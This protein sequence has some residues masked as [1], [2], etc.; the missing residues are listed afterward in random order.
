[1]NISFFSGGPDYV[2]IYYDLWPHLVCMSSYN[3]SSLRTPLLRDQLTSTCEPIFSDNEHIKFHAK[4]LPSQGHTSRPTVHIQL[5]G[6]GLH[7]SPIGGVSVSLHSSCHEDEEHP[8]VVPCVMMK[9][10][11]QN[12]LTVC[13]ARCRQFGSW[14]Y[15]MVDIWRQGDRDEQALC[16]IRFLD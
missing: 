15:A 5:F 8:S 3:M 14:D 1:M 4:V 2:Q 12:G 6:K 10:F 7:C 16:E 11:D 13:T 9:D